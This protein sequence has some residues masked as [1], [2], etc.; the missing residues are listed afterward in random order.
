MLDRLVAGVLIATTVGGC[1]FLPSGSPTAREFVSTAV[2]QRDPG[3]V[4]VN[5]DLDVAK[6]IS[7]Y[8]R[9][10]LRSLGGEGYEPSLVLK[11]GDVISTTVYE[12]TPTPIFGATQ[13]LQN[14]AP[15]DQPV[16]G[17]TATIP[18]Q[19]VEQNGFVPVPFGGSVKVG[20]LTPAQAG[21]AIAKALEGKATNPQAVVTLVSSILNVATVNGDVGRP[22]LVSLTIRG[23]HVL[24]VVA[25]AGGPKYPTYDT[26]LQLIRRGRVAKVNM[27]QLVTD[28]SQNIRVRPGDSIV[29]VHN[30]QS[31]A[32]LGAALK[33][34]QYDFNVEQVTLAEA[35][36]RSGGM[37]E[38]VA[39]VG[40]LY[41]LRF[42]PRDVLRRVLRADDPQTRLL[43]AGA[44]QIPVAYHLNLR[45]ASGY[46]T[47][48]SVQMRDKDVVLITNAESVQFSK[49]MTI[50]RTIAG[51]YYDFRVPGSAGSNTASRTTESTATTSSDGVN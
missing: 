41:L 25:S 31:F 34:S 49:L 18:S 33:V 32:V 5:L 9:P 23:E 37:N 35:I 36:A 2:T 40:D 29:V 39:D 17:H 46:F 11:P 30:P 12:V 10:G 19:V 16:S 1:S 7:A 50:V 13:G 26:D 14:S 45:G 27:Q 48:Q 20:G 22:G 44:A 4:Q 24:D 43:D 8:Q 6:A 47:S 42:E 28:P 38:A 51:S 3:F 21:K 15:S